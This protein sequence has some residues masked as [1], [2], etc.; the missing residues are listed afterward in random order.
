[1]PM[2]IFFF[3]KALST[4]PK[5]CITNQ[6]AYPM[7]L[8]TIETFISLLFSA[9]SHIRGKLNKAATEARLP[10]APTPGSHSSASVEMLC[11]S[12]YV[13]SRDETALD[14]DSAP[15][16]TS[17]DQHIQEPPLSPGEHGRVH[18]SALPRTSHSNSTLTLNLRNGK[19]Q[20]ARR[21]QVDIDQL[22]VSTSTENR[23]D[24]M[25]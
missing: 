1:M 23:Q 24:Y 7:Q 22:M 3:C 6:R 16:P 12:F 17:N 14:D 9:N 20:I 4:S 10:P 13:G 11:N 2:K 15:E 8:I 21:R 19:S 5:A 18:A 25:K